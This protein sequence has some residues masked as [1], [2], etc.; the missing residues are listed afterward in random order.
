MRVFFTLGT[1]SLLM[2]V[3]WN[4]VIVDMFAFADASETPSSFLNISTFYSHSI[5]DHVIDNIR[6]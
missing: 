4:I 5:G 1:A 3:L 2:G 6:K